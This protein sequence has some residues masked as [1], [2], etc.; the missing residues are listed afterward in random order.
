MSYYRVCRY[1]GCTL[2]PGEQ[3]DCTA[4]IYQPEAVRAVFSEPTSAPLKS[5]REAENLRKYRDIKAFLDRRGLSYG[6]LGD[7]L[8]YSEGAI[9]QFMHKLKNGEDAS[10]FVYAKIRRYAEGNPR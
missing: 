7:I 9:K 6:S 3:C 5:D 8:G 1:C 2:D 10:R 4:R